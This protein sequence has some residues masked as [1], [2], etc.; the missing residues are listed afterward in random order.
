MVISKLKFN[1]NRFKSVKIT[2]P[3]DDS[4]F[5]LSSLTAAK[6]HRKELEAAG[7]VAL[8]FV[9]YANPRVVFGTFLS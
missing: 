5:F 2:F 4:N 3:C 8:V 9:G 1:R 7:A 6:P